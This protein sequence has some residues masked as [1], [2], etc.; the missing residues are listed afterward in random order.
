VLL[1]RWQG[2]VTD[3][4][5]AAAAG[6]LTAGADP[7]FDERPA[8]CVVLAAEG[9]PAAP[10]TG[11]VITGLAAAANIEGVELYA[12][13]VDHSERGPGLV[14]SGGRVLTVSARGETLPDAR[15]RALAGAAAI[16]WPGRHYRGDI[17]ARAA[18]EVGT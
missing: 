18:L 11:D 6:S 14:T 5:A 10:R 7:A 2:D 17:A 4:L 12:A 9:Y 16:D 13:A 3:V 15:R 1:P 8:V